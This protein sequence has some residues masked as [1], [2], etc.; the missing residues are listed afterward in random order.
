MSPHVPEH[1]DWLEALLASPEDE[2]SSEWRAGLLACEVCRDELGELE[3]LAAELEQLGEQEQA[4]LARAEGVREPLAEG[5]LERLLEEHRSASGP[6][7]WKR[8]TLVAAGALAAGLLVWILLR[9][10]SPG[11]PADAVLGPGVGQGLSPR[12]EVSSFDTVFRWDLETDGW[13]VVKVYAEAEEMLLATSPRL[14]TH[15][16]QWTADDTDAWPARVRWEVQAFDASGQPVD[17]AEA[18]FWRSP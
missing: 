2:R 5:R 14:E 13:F 9:V 10:G 7:A 3:S 1:R 17:S 12:G 16:W 15:Q 18:S 4:D 6:P 11:L 8:R